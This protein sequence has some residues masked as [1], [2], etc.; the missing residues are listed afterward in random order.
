[1][2]KIIEKSLT[3]TKQKAGMVKGLHCGLL[4]FIATIFTIPCL[5]AIFNITYNQFA[6]PLLVSQGRRN[7]VNDGNDA[8]GI[9]ADKTIWGEPLHF[10]CTLHI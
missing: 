10:A 9:H 7:L 2:L 1:L 4:P 5:F 6:F 3:Y 8:V